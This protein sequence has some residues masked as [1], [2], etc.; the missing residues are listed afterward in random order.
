M[1]PW[2]YI[3]DIARQK[4]PE[5]GRYGTA[6]NDP[7]MHHEADAYDQGRQTHFLSIFCAKQFYI[8]ANLQFLQKFIS[9]NVFC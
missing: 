6:P 9:V 8:F 7:Q 4:E 2:L 5:I 1:V 3:V